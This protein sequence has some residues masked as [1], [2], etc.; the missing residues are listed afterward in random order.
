MAHTLKR[1]NDRHKNIGATGR[2]VFQNLVNYRRV[3]AVACRPG[4][5]GCRRAL[6]AM[7]ALL[8]TLG[9]A[10]SA[11]AQPVL[12]AS[13]RVAPLSH[14]VART[15]AP[16][17]DPWLSSS[18]CACSAL[19]FHFVPFSHA[20]T[21]GVAKDF[22][23]LMLRLAKDPEPG[24]EPLL[25]RAAA[26]AIS[27][28][29]T[30][31]M[32]TSSFTGSAKDIFKCAACVSSAIS[33]SHARR[34]ASD[35]CVR[36]CPE[37]YV[38]VCSESNMKMEDWKAWI[39]TVSVLALAGIEGVTPKLKK[40]WSALRA[41]LVYLL[42]YMPGQHDDRYIDE[43]R[44]LMCEYASLAEEHFGKRELMTYQLHTLVLHAFEQIKEVGPGAFVS[45][46]WL[47]RM[48]QSFKRRTKCRATR[49]P[50]MTACSIL[51]AL[52]GLE[53]H[54]A[55][56]GR[57]A[58]WGLEADAP[59]DGGDVADADAPALGDAGA[60]VEAAADAGAAA[61][62]P[63][64]RPRVRKRKSRRGPRDEANAANHLAGKMRTLQPDDPRTRQE[65]RA[66]Q[67]SSSTFEHGK[68]STVARVFTTP[69]PPRHPLPSLFIAEGRHPWPPRSLVWC[70]RAASAAAARQACNCRRDSG[71]EGSGWS[72]ACS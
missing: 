17:L 48:C 5:I 13:V 36:T 69:P 22:W 3:A 16:G 63:R 46:D 55:T 37:A 8:R 6:G 25:T 14:H 38:A 51:A 18:P 49:W 24:V 56:F 58:A 20:I 31:V 70:R 1:I 64:Q 15:N 40:M 12:Q 27:R 65:V 10:P 59:P 60:P 4:P 28:R 41:A 43:A 32:L 54:R 68:S 35:R 23:L 72:R 21:Y 71:M 7:S 52:F 19:H 53:H 39:T 29:A 30:R 42:Q 47:E 9:L 67:T 61:A 33:A 57:G 2:S 34:H 50:E 45:E 66:C 44:N 11:P 26:E 62:L